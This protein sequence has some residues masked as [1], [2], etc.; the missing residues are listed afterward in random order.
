[1]GG[2]KHSAG[3][4]PAKDICLAPRSRYPA[5]WFFRADRYPANLPGSMQA[6]PGEGDASAVRRPSGV[7]VAIRSVRQAPCGVAVDIMNGQIA[8]AETVPPVGVENDLLP[9]RRPVQR[10]IIP[11]I[12]R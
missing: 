12:P 4:N 5:M 2:K 6:R 1:M 7:N 3:R 10:C 9:V 8:L 11:S